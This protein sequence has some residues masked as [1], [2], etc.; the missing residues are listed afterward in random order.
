MNLQTELGRVFIIPYL[1]E[2][3]GSPQSHTL[4]APAASGHRAQH[5]LDPGPPATEAESTHSSLSAGLGP[6]CS[7]SFCDLSCF[8]RSTRVQSRRAVLG[9]WVSL[10]GS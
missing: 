9:K 6:G 8:A 3:L 2:Q 1:K 5:S 7:G 4:E 10:V